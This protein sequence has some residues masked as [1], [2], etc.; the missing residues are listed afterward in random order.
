MF[1][2]RLWLT[3]FRKQ[4]KTSNNAGYDIIDDYDLIE[5]SFLQQYGMRLRNVSLEWD[6]FLNLLCGLLPETPLGRVVAIRTEK[7]PEVLKNFTPE[8][9]KIRNQ[10]LS[11]SVAEV[12]YNTAMKNFE[13]M[14]RSMM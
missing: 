12:D 14:F 3:D 5:S 2:L 9:K 6:E 1:R 7:D 8:Q 4:S 11:K 10:W 13:A